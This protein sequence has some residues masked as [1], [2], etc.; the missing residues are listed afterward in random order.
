MLIA[1]RSVLLAAFVI[2]VIW[3]ASLVPPRLTAG[4]GQDEA[5]NKLSAELAKAKSDYSVAI[6]QA[7]ARLKKIIPTII[8]LPTEQRKVLEAEALFYYGACLA[9]MNK[10]AE[11]EDAFLQMLSADVTYQPANMGPKINR[12]VTSA[13]DKWQQKTG[14][15]LPAPPKAEAVEAPGTPSERIRAAIEAFWTKIKAG[16]P[17]EK[18]LTELENLHTETLA[19]ADESKKSELQAKIYDL[20]GEICMRA[21]DFEGAARYYRKML[22]T[23]RQFTRSTIEFRHDARR[24]VLIDYAENGFGD[25]ELAYTAVL[26]PV[27]AQAEVSIDSGPFQSNPGNIPLTKPYFTVSLRAKGY[28]P[29][30]RSELI[31]FPGQVITFKLEED[32]LEYR[33]ETDPPGAFVVIGDSRL[34]KKTPCS[35]LLQF[36]KHTVRL[37]LDGY[38]AWTGTL[39]LEPG[40]DP[41]AISRQLIPAKYRLAGRLEPEKKEHIDFPSSLAYTKKGFLYVL[42]T[43]GK[44]YIRRFKDDSTFQAKVGE[45]ASVYQGLEQPVDIAVDSK[46]N[47]YL[48]DRVKDAV[49]RFDS[50]AQGLGQKYVGSGSGDAKLNN[51]QG[52][53]FDSR[54]NLYVADAKSEKKGTANRL[55]VFG[56]DRI[57][58][59]VWP[60]PR[61]DEAP[62]D[63]TVNSKDEILAVTNA[64]VIVWSNDGEVLRTWAG[65][66]SDQGRFNGLQSIS[67]DDRG[68]IY[69]VESGNA[70]VLKFD[71]SGNFVG[72]VCDTRSDGGKRPKAVVVDARGRVFVAD[73]D[74]KA[75]LI[76]RGPEPAK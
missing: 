11:A 54:D 32:G 29:M 14:R 48:C 61:P 9:A 64:S 18:D 41:G 2:L 43:A 68:C 66:G 20:Q 74:L 26:A 36:G 49:F 55:V 52:I 28:K 15:A 16:G 57:Q 23:D 44:N 69:V 63:V 67:V 51:P 31:L 8:Q 56:P 17:G 62:I 1:R 40:Q 12:V 33:F 60:I 50:M 76:F 72:I 21:S 5:F 27:P 46:D 6:P 39:D 42:D 13:R 3:S 58:K 59:A 70:R 35:S 24:D 75:I 73:T 45:K 53:A 22:Y 30:A 71:E 65:T 7:A 25:R 38:A 47:V 34:D 4:G 10:T 37:E 19:L